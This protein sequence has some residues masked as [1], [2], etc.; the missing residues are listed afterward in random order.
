LEEFVNLS[1]SPIINVFFLG[2]EGLGNPK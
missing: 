1:I 2:N